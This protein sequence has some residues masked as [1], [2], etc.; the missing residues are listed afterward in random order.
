MSQKKINHLLTWAGACIL[1]LSRLLSLFTSWQKPLRELGQCFVFPRLVYNA[2]LFVPPVPGVLIYGD[3]N[4]KTSLS[5]LLG[6]ATPAQ[7]KAG[8]LNVGQATPEEEGKKERKH[9]QDAAVKKKIEH[10]AE[11]LPWPLLSLRQSTPPP[12]PFN[13]PIAPSRI[14]L[15]I[16]QASLLL[17]L[18]EKAERSLPH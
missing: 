17:S 6:E 3:C 10:Q 13:Q 8:K 9:R 5:S 12:P 1:P 2:R 4:T 11:S 14:Y 16:N 7:T 15:H 18:F